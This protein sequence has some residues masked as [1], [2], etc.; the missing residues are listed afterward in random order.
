MA[1]KTNKTNG[2]AHSNTTNGMT[3]CGSMTSAGPTSCNNSTTNSA[4][5]ASKAKQNYK[6]KLEGQNCK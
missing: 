1:K 6:S 2:A 3:N 4:Y 5:E